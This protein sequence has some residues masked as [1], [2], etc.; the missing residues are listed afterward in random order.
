MQEKKAIKTGGIASV[1]LVSTTHSGNIGAVARAMAVMELDQ[2]ILVSPQCKHLDEDTIT[3]AAGAEQILHS[4]KVTSSLQEA[5]TPFHR[6]YGFSARRR[7]LAPKQIVLRDAADEIASYAQAGDK[8]ALVFG[9]ERTGLSNAD[10]DRCNAVVNIP[11]AQSN[12]SLNLAAAVQVVSYELYC[13]N[14]SQPDTSNQAPLATK[15]TIDQ[16]F[17]HFSSVINDC[18]KPPSEGQLNRMQRRIAV[19]LA[20]AQPSDADVRMLRGLLTS[21]SRLRA[22]KVKSDS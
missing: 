22:A 10:L 15:A 11:T 4:A 12:W 7:E 5:L 2:M 8:L 14:A 20:N 18:C 16:L 19:L 13:T 17:E 21:V 6:A 9:P 3:R 1:I